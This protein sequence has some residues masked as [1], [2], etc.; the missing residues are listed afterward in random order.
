MA[1]LFNT[2]IKDTYQSLL[3]L[4]DN[5][6]LTTT[7][8]N[9]TDGLGNASPLY[10]STTQV[11]IGSTSGSAM[12]WDNV[13]N[14]LGIG[15]STPAYTL[16]I[17]DG[18]T[19][20]FSVV[21][22]LGGNILVGSSG[23]TRF[24]FAGGGT[25]L[26]MSSTSGSL[27][28]SVGNFV[29]GALVLG[30]NNTEAMRISPS[31]YNVNIN[32]TTDLTAKLGIKGS[33]STSATT[34]LL[35]QNSGGT[36]LFEVQDDGT[37]I[38]R[39]YT[40]FLFYGLQ[41]NDN[42]GGPGGMSLTGTPPSNNQI[43]GAAGL[44]ITTS[45]SFSS[46]TG[47]AMQFN[48]SELSS[49]S[50]DVANFQ[51]G[52]QANMQSGNA[53]FSQLKLVPN[54][55]TG[56]TYSGIVR[57]IYYNPSLSSVTGITS[58]RAIETVTGNVLLGTTSGNVGIGTSSPGSKLTVDGNISVVNN[59]SIIG[60][61]GSN[62]GMYLTG[63]AGE[64]RFINGNGAGWYYTWYQ[65]GGVEKMR[66]STG[67]NLLIGTT[68]DSG[69]K[70]DVNG[71][72]R[73]T[74]AVKGGEGSNFNEIYFYGGGDRKIKPGANQLDI[75]DSAGTSGFQVG[76]GGGFP[77]VALGYDS[78]DFIRGN[79][80]LSWNSSTTQQVVLSAKS[81]VNHLTPFF[82][83]VAQGYAPSAPSGN[84]TS[85]R[86]YTT[87]TTSGTYGNIIIGHNGTNATG[88]VGVGEASPTARLQVKGSGSTSATTSL[89]VQNSSST[90]SL[91]ITDDGNAFIGGSTLQFSNSTNCKII[92]N[93]GIMQLDNNGTAGVSLSF[94]NGAWG[95]SST[96]CFGLQGTGA[97]ASAQ[98]EIK[99][100]T[101]GFL[102]PRGTNAQMLAIVSPAEGLVFYDLTNHKLNVFDGTSWVAMH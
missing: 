85:L 98:V 79:A 101:R 20:L 53:T 5:T 47:A 54:F 99:S 96:V 89:L 38:V 75:T 82:D 58:H 49:T 67:D 32:S 29:N 95:S 59:N 68:T 102:P 83:I 66:L 26:V 31:T 60:Y 80:T 18:T 37:T 16:Q 48:T 62:Q 92:N 34:S 8:K 52:G 39:R 17:G 41:I 42:S 13:N 35:V 84:N 63:G 14:R 71:T 27:P 69:F 25:T 11:R 93:F 70:L 64:F 87:N 23:N 24:G 46:T 9:V 12:Y 61:V 72:A 91:E 94:T 81:Y 44:S 86:L 76:G 28:M 65:N 22:T 56:G 90:R 4:E 55:T 7:T 51:F 78:V 10:M 1:T 74:G 30:V 40:K 57:G 2:K 3:K 21:S 88:N 19:N 45:T 6:I 100:T 36:N 73:V 97:V 50:G 77:R 33:G 15:T 43:I